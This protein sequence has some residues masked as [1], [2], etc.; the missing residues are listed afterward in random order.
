RSLSAQGPAPQA[1]GSVRGTVEDVTGGVVSNVAVALLDL[2]GAVVAEVKTDGSGAFLFE[3][4][5]AGS[6]RVRTT[7]EGFEQAI[8]PVRVTGSR[9]T[10]VPK[11]VLQV[12]G[13]KADVTVAQDPSAVA[14]AA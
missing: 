3:A 12:A 2:S 8:A 9:R 5:R 7:F 11:L 14:T 1:Q 13:I 10:V 4:V 6:Y